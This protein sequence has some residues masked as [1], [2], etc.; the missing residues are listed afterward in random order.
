[1]SIIYRILHGHP[2]EAGLWNFFIPILLILVF[3]YIFNLIC[4]KF[5]NWKKKLKFLLILVAVMEFTN[6]MEDAYIRSNLDNTACDE[7][8]SPD[9]VYVAKTCYFLQS[10]RQS[11]NQIWLMIYD[12]KTMKL[13]TEDNRRMELNELHWS[14]DENGK[15]VAAYTDIRNLDLKIKLPPSWIHRLRAKLP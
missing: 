4:K 11:Y 13:L 12:A 15:T 5:T 1:M 8:T 10:A 3:L 14:L 2:L 9:G 6:Y 7:V